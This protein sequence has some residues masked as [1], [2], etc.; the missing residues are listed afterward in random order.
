MDIARLCKDLFADPA[1]ATADLLAGYLA[2]NLKIQA[3]VLPAATPT[4]LA[5]GFKARQAEAAAYAVQI[6]GVA[7]ALGGS[8]RQQQAGRV[9]TDEQRAT[10]LAELTA[11]N[12]LITGLVRVPVRQATVRTLLFPQGLGQYAAAG[13]DDL[14]ELLETF[15]TQLAATKSDFGPLAD[16][17]LAGAT[18]ALAPYAKLRAEQKK[19]QDATGTA[20]TTRNSLTPLL[21]QSLTEGLHLACL[22][23]APAYEQALD[24]F[25]GT[26]FDHHRVS[27]PA[28][29]HRRTVAAGATHSLYDLGHAPGNAAATVRLSLPAGAGGPLLL[30]RAAD[31]RAAPDAA[32]AQPVMPGQELLFDLTALGTGDWLVCHNDGLRQLA[33]AVTLA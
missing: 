32:T 27:N 6:N 3:V 1:L 28:G 22:I 25:D 17:V 21:T 5:A 9:L 10:A 8:Q 12:S 13:V 31:A 14:P 18:T 11:V 20:R 30:G 33:V 7:R 2:F 26:Y 29:T 16:A 24:W 15:L 19:Q 23:Y 4:W